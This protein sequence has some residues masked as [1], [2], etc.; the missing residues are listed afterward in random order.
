MDEDNYIESRV[1]DQVDW[2]DEKSVW[3]QRWSKRLQ[4][5]VIV[6][7]ALVPFLAGFTADLWAKISVGLLGVL[8][9]AVSALIGLYRFQEHWV[10]YRA[11]C[12]SLKH[13][14]FLFLTKT[15]PYNGES[16]FGLFVAR[17]EGLVSKEHSN[18]VQLMK[19]QPEE[20]QE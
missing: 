11:T 6:S 16:P 1:D 3:N 12:E 19:G 2:Y 13:E 14:K 15:Q 4:V 9:A 20:A 10:E 17:I 7:A 8:I 18:W 5:A